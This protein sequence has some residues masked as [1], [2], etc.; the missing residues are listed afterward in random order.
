M[1]RSLGRDDEV[2]MSSDSDRNSLLAEHF[3]AGRQQ[4]SQRGQ[5]FQLRDEETG[6]KI[7]ADVMRRVSFAW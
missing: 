3:E 4:R 6:A 5:N 1:S 7:C 2:Q